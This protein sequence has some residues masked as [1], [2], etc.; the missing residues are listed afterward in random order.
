MN[1][2]T[3]ACMDKMDRIIRRSDIT[4]PNDKD[5]AFKAIRRILNQTY[6]VARAVSVKFMFRILT[7]KRLVLTPVRKMCE[8]LYKG[9]NCMKRR[10]EIGLKVMDMK[11]ND[12]KLSCMKERKKLTEVWRQNT[13]VLNSFQIK[14]PVE[15]LAKDEIKYMTEVYIKE[16]KRKIDFLKD[17]QLQHN[18]NNSVN[19]AKNSQTQTNI[20][21]SSDRHNIEKILDNVVTSDRPLPPTFSSEPR[22]YGGIS[23]SEEEKAALTLPPK[24]TLYENVDRKN[25]LVEIETMVSKYMWELRK[26]ADNENDENGRNKS[27]DKRNKNKQRKDRRNLRIPETISEID[28]R[29]EREGSTDDET[30][31]HPTPAPP[32]PQLPRI[33]PNTYSS[34]D[35]ATTSH[36]LQQ[37]ETR[38]QDAER[39]SQRVNNEH[40]RLEAETRRRDNEDRRPRQQTNIDIP[41]I[42][43]ETHRQDDRHPTPTSPRNSTHISNPQP[44]AETRRYDEH[45]P[46]NTP[47]P[48]RNSTTIPYPRPEA[49]ARRNDEDHLTRTPCP[50]LSSTPIPYPRPEAETNRHG[51]ASPGQ[52]S[53]NQTPPNPVKSSREYHYDVDT[54]TFDFRKMRPTDL[55]F[56]KHV[57]L[58][59]NDNSREQTEEEIELAYLSHQLQKA[60]DQFIASHKVKKNITKQQ[61]EG[62]K[63]LQKRDDAVIFQTDKSSR[64]SID[65][66]DN[67]VTA[68][69]KHTTEDEII[70]EK[71]YDKLITEV[72]AHATMWSK[73][74]KAGESSGDYGPQR[75]KENMLSAEKCDAP[76]LYALR[77]DHKPHSEAE[78]GPPTRPV[79]GA[80]AAH[81]GRLSHLLS[82]VLKE[83]K[84]LDNDSCESTEDILAE[85]QDLNEKDSTTIR[86]NEKLVVGSLD[87]KALYPS[88]DVNFAAEV[89]AEELYRS[90]VKVS[91][92]SLDTEELG[93]YLVLNED[94]RELDRI[95]IREYC[96]TR[97]S[98]RGRKPNVTGQANSSQE[99]R[100]K[101][102]RPP[103]NPN[104][105]ERALKRMLCKALAIGIKKVMEAHVYKFD[106]KIRKQKK[107]GA[108]GLE[109]TG[110]LAGVFMMWWDRRMRESLREE[111]INVLMYKRYVDDIN[112]VLKT[113][114]DE[115]EKDIMEKVKSIGDKIHRSIQLEADYP[116]RYEDKKVPILDLKVWVDN[117]NK[118]VHEYYSKPVASK[119]VV[120]SE[121]AMPLKDR[122]T[123]L[124]QEILRIILRCSPLL[125]WERVKEHI[126]HYMLRMQFSGYSEQIRKQVLHSAVKAYRKI[127]SKVDKGERPLYRRKH[128]KQKERIKEKR[129]CKEEWFKSKK[130]DE[131][132]SVLFVQPTEKSELKKMYEEIVQ[133]SNCKVRIIERAGVSVKKKLQKSYP[134]LKEKC[135]ETCFV[136]MSEG[137]GNCKRSNVTYQIACT[138]PGCKHVYEG[139]SS[140]HAYSRG[141]EHLKSLAKK[142][143]DSVLVQHIK[144][145]HE[146]DFSD[147]P[148]FKFKMSVTQSH[149]TALSRLVTEAVNIEHTTKPLLNRKRGYR[150]NTVLSLSSLS[151]VS[152]C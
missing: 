51:N 49:E 17:R 63:K 130:D 127:R 107:G 78:A 12:A 68:C 47:S 42:E 110:E 70:E 76:P 43:A 87:V 54:N 92:E 1:K 7:T 86:Q 98:S 114:E 21:Q 2:L 108:I 104:P 19:R 96:P 23:I 113:S 97:I 126:E 117:N 128:W 72:N 34:R 133:K 33:T 95:G 84:R 6:A 73:I 27:L 61:H 99:R 146:N 136:C 138:R 52:Q 69:A 149:V 83:V 28:E 26:R 64:F 53:Q 40:P 134:F 123:V 100:S 144:E 80:T 139:E 79:C 88:I 152:H 111:E 46:T 105:D 38:R 129:Q 115:R 35:K 122:R 91:E 55:P 48:I 24:Y 10:K 124:T 121:S 16:K 4:N 119:A 15:L 36:P 71:E 3:N 116:D 74:L 103:E 50:T 109:M 93:L 145:K 13:E 90:D 143:E 37:A 56:N 131:Y 45:R 44:E 29:E 82:M 135:D 140:R 57:F 77:K 120:N 102:W 141:R 101:I 150:V 62:M 41:R 22:V 20:D 30:N 94:E 151:D 132:M 8:K 142:D 18:G 75:I 11:A 32:H 25:C 81:N 65:A 58:P 60:T 137:K 125:P 5:R 106:G 31:R 85:I 39:P 118:V 147:P 9:S 112:I 14:R 66:K 148:C 89:V 59:Q 67:Y